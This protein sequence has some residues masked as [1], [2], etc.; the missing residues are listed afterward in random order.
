VDLINMVEIVDGV[1][2]MEAHRNA[3]GL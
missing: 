3:L 2:L 1:D